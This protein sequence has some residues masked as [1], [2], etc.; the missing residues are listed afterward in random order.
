MLGREIIQESRPSGVVCPARSSSQGSVTQVEQPLGAG[1]RDIEKPSL[2]LQTPKGLRRSSVRKK[3][4]VYPDHEHRR[5]LKPLGRVNR[6]EG[7][8]F[9]SG[10]SPVLIGREQDEVKEIRKSDVA[11]FLG[12]V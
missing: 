9:L 6:H 12:R 11:P 8:L 2:L 1:N 7:D 3:V 10:I 4:L 5:K